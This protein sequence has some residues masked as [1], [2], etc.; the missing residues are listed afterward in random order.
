[1][2]EQCTI[3]TFYSCRHTHTMLMVG[4]GC[5]QANSEIIS[6]APFYCRTDTKAIRE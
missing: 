6:L 1:M 5:S 3:I 2:T 4:W